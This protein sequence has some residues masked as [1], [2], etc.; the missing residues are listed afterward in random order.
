MYHRES[1]NF[2]T[3]KECFPLLS[4]I[5]LARLTHESATFNAWSEVLSFRREDS[6]Y[7]KADVVRTDS[8]RRHQSHEWAKGE[9][10]GAS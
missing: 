4:T 2:A 1:C 7:L 3:V 8:K 10:K 9:S 5:I 6:S